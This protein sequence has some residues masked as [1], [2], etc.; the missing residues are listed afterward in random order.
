MEEIQHRRYVEHDNIRS[1]VGVELVPLL[2]EAQ[3]GKPRKDPATGYMMSHSLSSTDVTK[4]Q[5]PKRSELPAYPT[6][7]PLEEKAMYYGELAQQVT[8]KAETEIFKGQNSITMFTFRLF[9]DL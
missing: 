6:K 2:K 9:N 8:N 5:D 1:N 3:T 7:S 4:A